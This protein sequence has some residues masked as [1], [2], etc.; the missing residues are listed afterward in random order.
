[1][2][3]DKA[4]GLLTAAVVLTVAAFAAVSDLASKELNQL[5]TQPDSGMAEGSGT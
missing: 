3:A 4:I 2:N 1:M 5:A